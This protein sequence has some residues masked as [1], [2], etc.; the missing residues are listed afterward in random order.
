ML[1]GGKNKMD[2][3][4]HGLDRIRLPFAMEIFE[5]EVNNLDALKNQSY[6]D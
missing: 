4:I 3:S 2:S 1:H 5:V 6:G